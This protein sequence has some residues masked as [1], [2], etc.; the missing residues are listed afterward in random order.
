MITR[1]GLVTTNIRYTC[2]ALVIS[3]QEFADRLAHLEQTGRYWSLTIDFRRISSTVG[4]VARETTT[5]SGLSAP[6]SARA[7]RDL[8][9]LKFC[10]SSSANYH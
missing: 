2:G 3:W 1:L 8:G 6:C 4:F 5:W 10:Q 9:V 7:T